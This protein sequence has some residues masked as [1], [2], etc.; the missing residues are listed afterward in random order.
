MLRVATN[1]PHWP[2]A[3]NL[4]SEVKQDQQVNKQFYKPTLR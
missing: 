3:G 1:V 2:D 4:M